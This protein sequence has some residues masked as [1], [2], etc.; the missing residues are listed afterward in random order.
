MFEQYW[1][2]LVRGLVLREGGMSYWGLLMVATYLEIFSFKGVKGLC[3]LKEV[4]ILTSSIY[5]LVKQ[6]NIL[7]LLFRTTNSPPIS[8]PPFPLL[9]LHSSPTCISCIFLFPFISF[10][11]LKTQ[12]ESFSFFKVIYFEIIINEYMIKDRLFVQF[13]D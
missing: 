7:K 9:P 10:L 3:V 4:S 5:L 6:L 1:S 2:G 11:N 12:L 8:F 13:I